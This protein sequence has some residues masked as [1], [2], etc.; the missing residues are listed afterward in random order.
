MASSNCKLSSAKVH[1]RKD[2]SLPEMPLDQKLPTLTPLETAIL[3]CVPDGGI[4]VMEVQFKIGRSCGSTINGINK[5]ERLGIVT[6]EKVIGSKTRLVVRKGDKP[7]RVVAGVQRTMVRILSAMG[8]KWQHPST[9]AVPMDMTE[10]HIRRLLTTML[11]LGWVHR[12]CDKNRCVYFKRSTK[13]ER[14][15]RHLK[16]WELY[17]KKNDQVGQI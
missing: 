12:K 2:I 13:G 1:S 17:D 5:L 15:L 14:A 9:I 10:E 16:E 4:P 7:R 8:S 11:E 3:D 6:L